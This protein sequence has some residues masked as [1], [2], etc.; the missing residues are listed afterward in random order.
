MV[1]GIVGHRAKFGASLQVPTILAPERQESDT[2][3]KNINFADAISSL[4]VQLFNVDPMNVIIASGSKM[5]S[6]TGGSPQRRANFFLTQ[7]DA[8]SKTNGIVSK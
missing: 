3:R 2:T 7:R 1:P 6:S 4:K 8:V 5:A